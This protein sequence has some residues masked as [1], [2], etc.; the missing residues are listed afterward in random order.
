MPR[1]ARP[2]R[3]AARM[4]PESGSASVVNAIAEGERPRLARPLRLAARM[5]PE[6]SEAPGINAVGSGLRRIL[7]HALLLAALALPNLAYAQ[8]FQIVKKES[9]FSFQVS[10]TL[11]D[12][13]GK[14]TG[15]SGTIE[16]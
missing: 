14:A 12:F 2:L 4:N 16:I 5:H 9:S 13:E 8:S 1:R 3:L 6:R 7:G 11:G 10:S 15:F